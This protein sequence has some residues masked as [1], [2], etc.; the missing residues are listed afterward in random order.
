MANPVCNRC[1]KELPTWQANVMVDNHRFTHDNA[2]DDLEIVCKPCTRNIPSRELH[3][4]WELGWVKNNYMW[5]L[6]NVLR[7]L[8]FP[9]PMFHWSKEAVEKF[10]QLGILAFPQLMNDPLQPPDE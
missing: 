10:W 6:R 4:L 1:K 9:K 3:N 5:L 7:D 2:I 8:T